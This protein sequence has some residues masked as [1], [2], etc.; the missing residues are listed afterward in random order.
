[1]ENMTDKILHMLQAWKI[2]IGTLIKWMIFSVVIGGGIGTIASLFAHVITWVT[3]FRI[4]NPWMIFGL[5]VGGLLIVFLYKITGQGKNSGTNMVLLVVR[6]G[7]EAVP[8]R[9][10]PLILLS[11][12][13]THLFGGSS[14]R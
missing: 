10:A 12:A 8:G 7:E 9:I 2:L 3:E 14:G 13:I 11:T 6:S 4:M 5:P 1:M